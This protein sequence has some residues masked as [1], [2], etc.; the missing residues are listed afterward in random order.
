MSLV[1]IL[2][3]SVQEKCKR[4]I[5]VLGWNEKTR[6]GLYALCKLF[7][8]NEKTRLVLRYL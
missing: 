8:K 7:E 1:K 5:R 4:S 3:L 2:S 6:F